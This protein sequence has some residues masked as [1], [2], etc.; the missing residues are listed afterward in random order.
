MDDGEHRYSEAVLQAVA[1]G[2]TIEAI[3][4]L[5]EETGV[6]L[7]E[8]KDEIDRLMREQRGHHSPIAAG[9][10]APM[11]EQGGAGAVLRIIVVVV[12]LFAI[13]KFFL[14]N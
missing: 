4:Q 5:R 8:A 7:K 11:S 9:E 6:G 3:K 10:D 13:Y 14:A 1:A 12:V 2:R